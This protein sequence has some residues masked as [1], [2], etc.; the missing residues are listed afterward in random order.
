MLQVD[1]KGHLEMHNNTEGNSSF[2]TST[3]PA[4]AAV[5]WPSWCDSETETIKAPL[6]WRLFPGPL[7]PCG[8]VHTHL[9]PLDSI[10]METLSLEKYSLCAYEDFTPAHH[11]ATVANHQLWP[12]ILFKRSSTSNDEVGTEATGDVLCVELIISHRVFL[13]EKGYRNTGFFCPRN[14]KFYISMLHFHKSQNTM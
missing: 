13:P 9:S 8:T 10:T 4:A 14:G 5:D 1:T 2:H 3:G 11:K 6:F 7:Q 12:I